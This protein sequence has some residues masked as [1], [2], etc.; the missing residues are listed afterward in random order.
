MMSRMAPSWF[1][2]KEERWIGGEREAQWVEREAWRVER[3]VVLP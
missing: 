2:W 1:D 3:V